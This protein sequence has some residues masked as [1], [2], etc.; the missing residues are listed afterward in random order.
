MPGGRSN[1][2]PED[3]PKIRSLRATNS[4]SSAMVTAK[5]TGLFIW[6]NCASIR[7][8][9]RSIILNW[10]RRKRE[11]PPRPTCRVDQPA[12]RAGG[13]PIGA[14]LIYAGRYLKVVDKFR[15]RE[16]HMPPSPPPENQAKN[17]ERGAY[18]A[19]FMEFDPTSRVSL[20][21]Q[22]ICRL[23]PLGVRV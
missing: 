19:G 14:T 4:G 18:C 2:R 3:L 15:R 16:F 5:S 12:A 10:F 6:A 21:M 20:V 23:Y 22:L 11:Y 1:V 13:E 8:I 7:S 9:S 17:T